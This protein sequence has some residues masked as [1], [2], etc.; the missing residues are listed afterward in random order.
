[1]LEQRRFLLHFGA[2]PD[3]D[4]VLAALEAYRSADGGYAF[5]LEP[6]VRGP[7]GQPIALPTALAVLAEAGTSR[8]EG[9]GG[10]VPGHANPARSVRQALW[11]NSSISRPSVGH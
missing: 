2:A 8:A 10:A 3:P 5:G 11:H 1:M 7:S 4:G 6:D 9:P